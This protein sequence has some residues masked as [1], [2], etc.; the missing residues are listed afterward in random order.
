MA[1]QDEMTNAKISDITAEGPD[2]TGLATPPAIPGDGDIK[3]IIEPKKK[4]DEPAEVVS[5]QAAFLGDWVRFLERNLRA[6]VPVDNGAPSGKHK[7]IIEFVVDVDGSMSR[8]KPLT[9]LGYGMEEEAMRVIRKAG[10]WS[11]AIWQGE[12]VKAYRRQQIT[13]DIS[14]Q[15]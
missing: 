9:N 13:F 1:T 2:D 11:P 14:G 5:V 4:S 15:D 10:K 6:D 3:N 7:V 12:A 8:I